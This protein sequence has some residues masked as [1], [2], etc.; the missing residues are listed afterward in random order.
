MIALTKILLNR[1]NP[2]FKENERCLKMEAELI[3]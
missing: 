3:E 1:Y 2:A